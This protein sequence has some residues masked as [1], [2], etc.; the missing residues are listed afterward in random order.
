MALDCDSGGGRLQAERLGWSG[1]A[2]VVR[3]MPHLCQL[4]AEQ[5][6]YLIEDGIGAGHHHQRTH[7]W[8]AIAPPA[9]APGR[10]PTAWQCSAG[11]LPH[12]LPAFIFI[13]S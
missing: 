5:H 8:L 11:L 7:G 10:R 13:L 6:A 9:G 3:S 1:S 2:A 4:C 12:P